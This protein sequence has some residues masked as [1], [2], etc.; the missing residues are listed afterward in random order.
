MK[1]T[2]YF[3]II[4]IISFLVFA[5]GGN[6]QTQTEKNNYDYTKYGRLT[7][8]KENEYRYSRSILARSITGD[9][10]RN[11]LQRLGIRS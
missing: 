7:D 6:K 9:R 1:K 11:S 2:I 10:G 8:P 3:G 4:S 5:C